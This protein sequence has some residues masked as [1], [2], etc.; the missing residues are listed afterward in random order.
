MDRCWS[1]LFALT[2]AVCPAAVADIGNYRVHCHFSFLLTDTDASTQTSGSAWKG[3]LDSELL[4]L[5]LS[6]PKDAS[7]NLQEEQAW[8]SG[9][10][11][12]TVIQGPCLILRYWCFGVRMFC[13]QGHCKYSQ[14]CWESSRHECALVNYSHPRTCLQVS[15]IVS[16]NF[17]IWPQI[18]GIHR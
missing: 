5:E 9:C 8:V 6:K 3:L 14:S 16:T 10:R 1:G 15:Y 2:D 4:Q 12:P 13:H 18:S 17:M 7:E 11:I